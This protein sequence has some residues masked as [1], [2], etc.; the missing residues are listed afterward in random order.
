MFKPN[1]QQAAAIDALEIACK[2][3]GLD[4]GTDQ[5][6]SRPE[7]GFVE[8]TVCDNEQNGEGLYTVQIEENGD[9]VCI[10]RECLKGESGEREW[11]GKPQKN[12]IAC[13][14]RFIKKYEIELGFVLHGAP[15]GWY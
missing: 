4:A 8:Y 12:L 6:Y 10:K 14:K 9:V 2:A 3:N 13:M 7:Y 15:L 1:S 11:I 5:P